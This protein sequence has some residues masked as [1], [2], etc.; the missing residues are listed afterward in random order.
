M[1]EMRRVLVLGAGSWGTALSVQLA[2]AGV[3]TTLWGHRQAHVDALRCNR[4]NERY[5]PGIDLPEQLSYSSDFASAVAAS[6]DLLVVT[7]SHVFGEIVRDALKAL[8]QSGRIAWACKGFEPG[9]GR[10]LHDL[11]R[12]IAGAE[13]PLAVVTGPSFAREVALGMPTAVT[14]AS[15]NPSFAND[16]A[17][18]LHHDAFR[19]YTSSDIV[20]A[21][22]GGAVK[23]VLAIATGLADG[24]GL[25]E[26]ARAALITRGL[27]EIMRLGKAVGARTETLT[28]L[29]GMGDLVLT[30][31]GSLSRNRSMGLAL[32]EGKSVTQALRE[33]GQVVEGV[34]SADEV[35]RLA[36]RV[37]VELPISEQVHMILEGH[38]T[39][40]KGLQALLS[41][42]LTSEH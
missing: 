27:A 5:L 38:T 1:S 32:G 21:E 25:G 8:R 28:G 29:A 3:P 12:D 4:R 37:G 39:P 19:T 20:G 14:V 18:A 42:E 31:T 36:R 17:T 10:F 26:N 6:D 22:L 33:I 15:E 35:M 41:R 9:T 30:C 40:Q 34:R 24:M 23:N 13:L 2:R 11:A 16:L 7:P